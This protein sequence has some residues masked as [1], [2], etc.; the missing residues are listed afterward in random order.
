MTAP[1][2]DVAALLTR[3]HAELIDRLAQREIRRP[4]C[5]WYWRRLLHPLQQAGL[6]E[7]IPDPDP[8]IGMRRIRIAWTEAGRIATRTGGSRC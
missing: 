3:D 6:L 5:F 2:L 4:H 7:I 1:A 8:K